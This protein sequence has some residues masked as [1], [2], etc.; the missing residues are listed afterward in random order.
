MARNDPSPQTRSEI[1]TALARSISNKGESHYDTVELIAIEAIVI[2]RS[3]GGEN[4]ID[5][6]RTAIT[7]LM[8]LERESR[9]ANTVKFLRRQRLKTIIELY[10]EALVGHAG[11]GT[12]LVDA[13]IASESFALASFAQ[14]Q[15]IDLALGKSLARQSVGSAELRQLIRNVQDADL[16]IEPA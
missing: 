1:A 14:T 16:R 6:L 10:I 12:M 9:S 5:R 4:Q 3:G 15:S 13:S 7:N 8:A 2:L 11:D